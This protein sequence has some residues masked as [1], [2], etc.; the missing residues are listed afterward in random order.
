MKKE[1]KENDSP[2]ALQLGGPM[3]FLPEVTSP[4]AQHRRRS[5]VW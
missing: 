2:R 4:R 1:I 5:H 3:W